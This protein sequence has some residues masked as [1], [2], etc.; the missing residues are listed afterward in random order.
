MG[1]NNTTGM[2]ASYVDDIQIT[3]TST[4]IS[5][6]RASGYSISGFGAGAGMASEVIGALVGLGAVAL[7]VL[8]AVKV[9]GAMK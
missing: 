1:T 2:Q 9:V 3:P 7:F 8:G 5:D 6:G 4:A